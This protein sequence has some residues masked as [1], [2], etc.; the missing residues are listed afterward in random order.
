[1]LCV[2]DYKIYFM[3]RPGSGIKNLREIQ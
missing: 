1:M 3:M 2:K